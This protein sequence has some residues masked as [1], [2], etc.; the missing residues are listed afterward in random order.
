VASVADTIETSPVPRSTREALA[1]V[2]T[3]DRR[4][5]DQ[6]PVL[7]VSSHGLTDTGQVR[8][9]N[10]DQFVI[11][12]IRRMLRI[13]HSS[14]QQPSALMGERIGHLFMVAD[15]M[16]GHQA[17]EYASAMAVASVENIILNT[18]GWLFRLQ[19]EGV[20][21]EFKEA[22]RATDRW[23]TEAAQR[24][25]ELKGMGTTLTLG[26]VTDAVLYI[27]HVG[28]SRC[29]LFRGKRLERLTRDH[30]YVESL[31]SEGLLKPEE[32]VHHRMRN[33]ITNAVGGDTS[34]VQPEVH[35]HVI[36]PGDAILLCSDG[37]SEMVSDEDIAEH[38]AADDATPEA[39]CQALVDKA[40]AAGGTDNIT[41][42]LARFNASADA[43]TR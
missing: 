24:Q 10:E 8:S 17:G 22:V 31:V 27:A 39:I 20:L 40:N 12:E 28:D 36:A 30:T 21:A 25:P 26:Y 6:G 41:V 5:A 14:L 32:A 19:G 23:V 43:Q 34:G 35:K 7:H 16:G 3:I 13:R 11:A 42:V 38:L 1:S 18:I 33:I 15:G 37:L 9:H 29:Y 4:A 2:P